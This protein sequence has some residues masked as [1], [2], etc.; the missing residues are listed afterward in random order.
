M[1][2]RRQSTTIEHPKIRRHSDSPIRSGSARENHPSPATP[3]PSDRMRRWSLPGRPIDGNN[4]STIG[5]PIL[6]GTTVKSIS[7]TPHTGEA[8]STVYSG[9]YRNNSPG[10]TYLA[11]GR[12]KRGRKASP[13]SSIGNARPGPREMNVLHNQWPG[14]QSV[15]AS[16][17]TP[18]VRD[19]Y[20]KFV[21][22]VSQRG[23]VLEPELVVRLAILPSPSHNRPTVGR[24]E[25]GSRWHCWTSTVTARS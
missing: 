24:P 14:G 8:L 18:T 1:M 10:G 9:R 11:S 2:N 21:S 25:E 15:C 20:T 4:N 12:E 3:I 6:D 19:M 17:A 22:P 13:P 23:A 16:A 7:A 5:D